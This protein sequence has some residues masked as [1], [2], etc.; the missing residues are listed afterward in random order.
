MNVLMAIIY[1]LDDQS[2]VLMGV[3]FL[4]LLITTF[5][6]GRKSRFERDGQMIFDDE[7]EDR[8]RANQD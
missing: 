7:R 8:P 2:I 5:W 3:V 6:P 1:W 4:L